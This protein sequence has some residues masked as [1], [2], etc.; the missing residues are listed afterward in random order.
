VRS[1]QA[2]RSVVP[3]GDTPLGGA[4]STTLEPEAPL[5]GVSS[6]AITAAARRVARR[7]R[8]QASAG[9][10]GLPPSYNEQV[11]GLVAALALAVDQQRPEYVTQLLPRPDAR[12]GC[13]LVEMLQTELL[14]TW[15]DADPPPTP[16]AMLGT[17][18]ALQLVRQA[19]ERHDGQQLAAQLS[20]VQG[21]E[22]FIEVIH[23]LRSPLTSIL[24]LAE[25]LQREQSGAVNDVQHRQLGLIYSAALGLSSIVS[26]AIELARGGSELADGDATPFSITELVD[27]VRAIVRPLAEEKSLAVRLVI[28]EVD[29]RVGH[30]VA[31]SRVLLNLT[32]NA[33]KFTDRGLVEIACD[34]RGDG[35][36][37]ISVQDT[38]PGINP[39]EI[40]TLFQPFRRARGRPG[41][42]FSGTGLGLAITR[43]LVEALGSSLQFETRAGWGTR[44]F[45]ELQLPAHIAFAAHSSAP[46]A[47]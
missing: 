28:P 21:L 4:P 24:F 20:G 34:D 11:E 42:C 26:D 39:T 44:F 5:A 46:R 29:R 30:P 25:T 23:D 35:R 27:S 12:L 13:R 7:W 45:F 19:I 6:M 8:D 14:A 31:L 36:V 17:L 33:L 22:L 3:S 40:A 38:G 10:A 15:S 41:Y 37:V 16:A 18:N 47:R 1:R 43:R 32:T 2:G 9:A